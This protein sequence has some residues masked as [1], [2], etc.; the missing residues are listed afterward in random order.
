MHVRWEVIAPSLI[1]KAPGDK[2]KT[3]TRDCRRLARLYRA[4]KL[5]AIRIPTVQEQAVRD[6]CRARADMVADRTRARHRL[7]QVPAASRPALAG[8]QRL[9]ADPRAL[10]ASATLRG[11]RPGRDLCALPGGLAA[12]DAQLEAIQ[13]DLAG[14]AACQSQ[15]PAT[16]S[17][18][19]APPPRR[20]TFHPGPR[21]T[22]AVFTCAK[23]CHPPGRTLALT[24]RST[25]VLPAGSSCVVSGLLKAGIRAD[26]GPVMHAVRVV[27]C[28]SMTAGVRRRFLVLL[29]NRS[30]SQRNREAWTT[31]G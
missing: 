1:P 29:V 14:W 13:A 26:P 20:C 25:S 15:S 4:G 24:S 8:R 23:S 30:S 17:W 22:S 28:Q 18:D 5:V 3:D 12:R 2:V 27:T 31:T 11:T 16:P 9:D 7:G 19:R 21:A 10:A 6:L